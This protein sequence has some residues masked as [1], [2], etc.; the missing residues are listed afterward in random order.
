MMAALNSLFVPAGAAQCVRDID[1]H[2]RLYVDASTPIPE[3][4]DGWLVLH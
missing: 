2:P 4:F 1:E 3:P